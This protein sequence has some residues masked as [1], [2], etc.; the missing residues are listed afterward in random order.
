[1]ELCDNDLWTNRDWDPSYLQQL[2]SDE[3][4]DY[5]DMWKSNVSDGELVKECERVDKYCPIIEDIS[6]YDDTLCSAVEKIESE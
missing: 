5:S 6:L 3:F 2:F 4:Y 1:M